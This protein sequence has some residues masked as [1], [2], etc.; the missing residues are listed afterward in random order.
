M[1]ILEELTMSRSTTSRLSRTRVAARPTRTAFVR[2]TLRLDP[3][4][5][6]NL[7]TF[8][9]G[10]HTVT[11]LYDQLTA[12]AANYPDITTLFTYGYS[13]SKTVGG[14]TTPDGQFLA[15]YDLKALG[16]TNKAIPGPKPSLLLVAGLNP[17]EISGPEVASR[18]VD[19]LTQNYGT[20]PD[21][22][23]LVD[24]HQLWVVPVA[25]PDGHWYVEQGGN[26]PWL[27][28]KNGHPNGCTVWPGNNGGSYGVNNDRNFA[29][30][31]GGAGSSG[32]P[33]DDWYRGA[34]VQSEPETQRLQF[35]VGSLF[36]D[37]RGPADGTPTP[38]DTPGLLI[39][40]HAYGG[41]VAWP[42]AYSPSAAPNA[43]GLA[44]IGQKLAT[45]N[46]YTAGQAYQTL[47]S[48]SGTLI[49]SAYGIV[50]APSLRLDLAGSGYFPP[51]DTVDALFNQNLPAL[52]YAAKAAQAPYLLSLGPDASGVSAQVAGTALRVAATV[53]DVTSGDQT[54]GAAEFYLDTPPWVSG[55]IPHAMAPA[56]G[57]FDSPTEA[58]RGRASTSGLGQGLHT[59]FVRGR[60][61]LGNW[62]PVS[63]AYF[64]IA[65]APG[66][67]TQPSDAARAML[68]PATP[69][70][71][72][73]DET[74]SRTRA[75]PAPVDG[76]TA[77]RPAEG[78]GRT[79]PRPGKVVPGAR[80]HDPAAE[81]LG[82]APRASALAG[83]D[84]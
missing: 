39:D 56:D 71:P 43:A 75:T 60:D 11:E 53:S 84:G 6:R 17:R 25:N 61:S 37:I 65:P 22:T 18:W 38:P 78:L 10:Y 79:N 3:L 58:V 20:D 64:M 51:Y 80:G 48:A 2:C 21:V 35:L 8:Y 62:G 69:A 45:L 23:W 26:S 57:A 81:V 67:A 7:L 9:G 24:Y 47:S 63:A 34:S 83:F 73:L 66:T 42:W 74:A 27:W 19:Y 52:R 49:D 55:A 31:W 16:I 41:S 14:V 82:V 72:F 68:R 50:G 4:E 33:C 59:V 30:G 44:A 32:N 29:V 70:F 5:E 1:G 36:P 28:N 46:G 76:A 15:G 12:V 77:D 13:Y 40:L 54:I